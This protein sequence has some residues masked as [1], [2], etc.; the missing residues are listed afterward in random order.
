MNRFVR[1]IGT[2][3]AGWASDSIADARLG[4]VSSHFD[5]EARRTGRT[6]DAPSKSGEGW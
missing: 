1:A 4:I 6:K 5:W 2:S 3:R